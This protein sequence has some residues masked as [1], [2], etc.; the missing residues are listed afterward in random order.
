VFV[1]SVQLFRLVEFPIETAW[2]IVWTVSL[3]EAVARATA[4]QRVQS[5]G[6]TGQLVSEP[7]PR[8][9]RGESGQSSYFNSVSAAAQ[10][11]WKVPRLHRTKRLCWA[12]RH[13]ADTTSEGDVLSPDQSARDAVVRLR[14]PV[15][16]GPTL[17]MAS[18]AKRE[19]KMETSVIRIRS[20]M[21]GERDVCHSNSTAHAGIE[22]RW[23]WGGWISL[24]EFCRTLAC[25]QHLEGGVVMVGG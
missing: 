16:W 3:S 24:S 6:L 17:P 25:A 10:A 22:I 14:H 5:S 18:L 19:P 4:P 13:E 11:G 20:G 2:L 12:L 9:V 8:W 15:L 23:W 7:E 21:S 1:D